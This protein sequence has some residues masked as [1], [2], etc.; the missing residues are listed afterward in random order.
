MH[1]IGDDNLQAV[2]AE[3]QTT[4]GYDGKS[5]KT[6][7]NI[8]HYEHKDYTQYPYEI[9][10]IIEGRKDLYVRYRMKI[11]SNMLGNPNTWRALFEYKT[12]DYKDPGEGGTGF[13]LISYIYTDQDGNPSWRTFRAIKIVEIPYGNVIA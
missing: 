2:Y 4:I 9:L 11:D 3:L 6:L 10:N 13:R 8:E 1:H 5:T 7:Y 12:K